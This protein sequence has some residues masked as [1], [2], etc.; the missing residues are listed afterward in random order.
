MDVNKVIRDD[1]RPVVAVPH[2]LLINCFEAPYPIVNV[3]AE[4][5]ATQPRSLSAHLRGPLVFGG[6]EQGLRN[7]L[8]DVAQLAVSWRTGS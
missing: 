4:P 2:A 7:E 6:T 1:A 8:A 3:I 5:P